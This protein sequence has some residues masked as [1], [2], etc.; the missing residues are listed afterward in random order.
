[1]ILCA[2]TMGLYLAG[3][4]LASGGVTLEL[5]FA[6]TSGAHLHFNGANKTF[7]FTPD[8][9]GH[10]FQINNVS[11]GT[12]SAMGLFG[13]IS[14][15][16][17]IGT[18]HNNEASVTGNGVLTVFD[19]SHNLTANLSLVEIDKSTSV[20]I[21]NLGETVNLSNV[22]YTGTNLDLRE[23]AVGLN[24]TALLSFFDSHTL[25]QL[26]TGGRTVN[27][28]FAGSLTADAPEP[29]TMTLFLGAGPTIAG[30]WF[31]RRRR[32]TAGAS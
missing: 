31:A 13:T 16:F 9:S 12:G 5:D 19:G 3:G 28:G 14:G 17:T 27:T 22:H 8:A 1:L 4:G 18:L 7:S 30:L 6:N 2:V 26:R 29:A 25:T 11:E 24:P 32:E 23:L 15:T 21:F 20:G 10:D